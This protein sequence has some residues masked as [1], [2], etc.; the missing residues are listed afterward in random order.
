MANVDEFYFG[1]DWEQSS[2][3]II[4]RQIHDS[5]LWPHGAA[6]EIGGG[7]KDVL[8]DGL[9]PIL[10]I[11]AVA[12]RAA[13]MKCGVV[14]SWLGHL[15]QVNVAPGFISRQYVANILTY[16]GGNAATWAAAYNVGMPVYIDDSAPMSSGV[17]LSLSPLNSAGSANPLAGYLVPAQDEYL[18]NVVGGANATDPW[19]KTGNNAATVETLVTVMLA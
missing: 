16:N 4:T 18:D 12:D 9:H 17:T 19:P 14:V 2:G 8:A 6:S 3:P 13:V 11:G 5:D 7:N 15:A 1:T 10:A